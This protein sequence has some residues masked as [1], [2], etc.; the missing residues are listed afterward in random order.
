MTDN[1][2]VEQ[3]HVRTMA[4][5]HDCHKALLVGGG[6]VYSTKYSSFTNIKFLWTGVGCSRPRAWV[7]RYFCSFVILGN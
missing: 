4:S 5:F 1:K 7:S 3:Q 6:I 2:K